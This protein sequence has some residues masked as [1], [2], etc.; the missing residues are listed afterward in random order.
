MLVS[1]RNSMAFKAQAFLEI[2][3]MLEP[4]V[5]I[6]LLLLLKLADKSPFYGSDLSQ[7]PMKM[8]GIK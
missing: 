3:H 6:G 8:L 7:G 1:P 5:E 2:A 4:T